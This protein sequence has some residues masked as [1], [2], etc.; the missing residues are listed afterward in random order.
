VSPDGAA[1]MCDRTLHGTL[2]IVIMG[3]FGPHT[4]TQ[5]TYRPNMLANTP[6]PVTFRYHERIGVIPL[7]FL[8]P[9]FGNLH[10]KAKTVYQ[11]KAVIGYGTAR[12]IGV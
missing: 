12:E 10:I 1:P 11:N 8:L 4:G 2:K 6:K 9:N 5:S 3:R 7:Q